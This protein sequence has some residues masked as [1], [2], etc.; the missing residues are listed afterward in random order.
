MSIPSPLFNCQQA[1][2]L[3][4]RRADAPLPAKTNAQLWAHLRLCPYCRRYAFQSSFL[5]RQAKAAAEAVV[6]ADLPLP[7]SLRARLQQL[8]DTHEAGLQQ[9]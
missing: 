3:L 6:P 4:E 8:I 2:L 9:E 5:A 7:V 1:T